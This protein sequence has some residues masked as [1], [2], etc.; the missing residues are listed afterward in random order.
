M[1]TRLSR[2]VYIVLFIMILFALSVPQLISQENSEN[3]NI[4]AF[5]IQALLSKKCYDC[6]GID[7]Q[8]SGLRLD[9]RPRALAGGNSKKAGIVPGDAVASAIVHRM[10]LPS[11]HE[12]AMPPKDREKLTSD[13]ILKIIHWIYSGANWP[14][15]TDD[16]ELDIEKPVQETVQETV[17]SPSDKVE[18]QVDFNHDILPVFAENCIKCHGMDDKAADLGLDSAIALSEANVDGKIIVPGNPEESEL[19][20]RISLP[21]DDGDIM[22]PTGAGDPLTQ[23]QIGLIRQWIEAGANFGET[24]SEDETAGS[25]VELV[26]VP[27]ASDQAMV[28]LEAKGALAVPLAQNTNFIQVDFSQVSDQIGDE[29]LSLL[30]PVAEQLSWLNLS[31]SKV[32]DAGLELLTKF[33]NLKRLHLENTGIGDVGLAHLKS[34]PNLEYLNLYGTNISDA[35]LQELTDLKKL[36]KIYLWRTKV[37][38]EGIPQLRAAQ[39]ELEINFGWEYELKQKLLDRLEEPVS[40]SLELSQ[41]VAISAIVSLVVKDDLQAVDVLEKEVDGK[42][43]AL[44]KAEAEA[45]QE[46]Y[47]KLVSLFDKDSCCANAHQDGKKCDHQCCLDAFAQNK[48]CLKCNPGAAEQKTN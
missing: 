10:T 3:Q 7:R 16:Q 46:A 8:K 17:S 34:L 9:D 42:R 41:T 26:Q 23:E 29:H 37:T 38:E 44:K 31:K 4:V 43:Q 13:E 48:V 35:G 47:T 32:S 20:K 15:Y 45:E 22:P 2:S 33:T 1:N 19:F 36:K 27:P 21:A 6:H 25:E 40:K 39:P 18:G 5:E 28:A 12:S 14:T 24:S 11:D 30:T